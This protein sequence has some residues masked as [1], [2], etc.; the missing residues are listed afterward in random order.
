MK[1]SRKFGFLSSA[2]RRLFRNNNK[3]TIKNKQTIKV[4]KKQT[5]HLRINE[6]VKKVWVSLERLAKAVQEQSA[7][8]EHEKV[9]VCVQESNM[10]L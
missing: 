3:R 5:P 4:N 9:P 1:I 2:L 6:K 7:S 10:L 8:L